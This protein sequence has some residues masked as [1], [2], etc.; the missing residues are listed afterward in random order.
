MNGFR[1]ESAIK[2][3]TQVWGTIRPSGGHV[4]TRNSMPN[5]FCRDS[6]VRSDNCLATGVRHVRV[7][8]VASH[9]FAAVH[10][11]LRQH[12][13]GHEARELRGKPPAQQE[14]QCQCSKR[15][16]HVQSIH[17]RFPESVSGR[18]HGLQPE[19]I[20]RSVD[21]SNR[22]FTLNILWK[23]SYLVRSESCLND[24]SRRSWNA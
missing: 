20:Q 23:S 7:A 3:D 13:I 10:I 12:L 6:K 19:P 22:R 11:R 4:R 24:M 9:S 1:C 15:P 2:A 5:D 17:Q 8:A 21:A 14:S 16:R 18:R